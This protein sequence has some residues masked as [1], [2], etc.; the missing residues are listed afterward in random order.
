[1]C[2]GEQAGQP[3]MDPVIHCNDELL[4][5]AGGAKGDRPAGEDQQPLPGWW[6]VIGRSVLAGWKDSGSD[7]QQQMCSASVSRHALP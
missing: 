4:S 6:Q 2:R 3:G 1:M 7:H 5:D